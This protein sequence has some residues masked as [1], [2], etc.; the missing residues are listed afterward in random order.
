MNLPRVYLKLVLFT[1]VTV[2]LAPFYFFILLVLFRWRR[3]IGP[4]LV[5]FYSRICLSIFRVRAEV[6][7]ARSFTK[8]K[9]GVLI[10]SNHSS[11]LDIFILSSLFGSVFVSKA[12]VKYYPI[13]GQIAWLA[14]VVFFDRGSARERTRVLR[15]IAWNY[16]DRILAVFP[17]GTTGSIADRLRFNRG[18]F[19]VTELNRDI[20]LLP[21]TLR[22]K[23]DDEVSW[24]RPQTLKENAMKVSARKRI[25]VKVLVH[26][27]VTILDYRGKTAP[28]LCEIVERMVL[29]PL[30]K[31][32]REI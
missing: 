30:Q 11:F 10:I 19:T 7:N 1:F 31:P 28:Q 27:P 4:R 20:T 5:Q 21:L 26:D 24:S 13:I 23:H 12:E 2:T 32:Y 3:D 17:Q 16:W 14:G 6:R 8:R 29:E 18:I 25:R 15:K 22:Y 9:G